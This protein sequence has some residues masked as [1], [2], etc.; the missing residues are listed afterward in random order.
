M[1]FANRHS[2]GTVWLPTGNP[3]TTNI[4]AADF[5]TSLTAVGMGG[6][7]GSLG[8]TFEGGSPDRTY[9]RVQLDSG[10]NASSPS[11][12]VAAN[13][14]LYWKDKARYIVTNDS[15]QALGGACSDNSAFRTFVSG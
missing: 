7:P 3:D 2:A 1:A 4:S 14:L 11:G 15:A 6:Q 9:Q 13:Q 10:A 5:G 12:V 8:I